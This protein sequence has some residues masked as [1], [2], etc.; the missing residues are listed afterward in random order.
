MLLPHVPFA[1][2]ILPEVA[3][4]AVVP[5][6]DD[7]RRGIRARQ[8]AVDGLE[9]LCINKGN[10]IGICLDDLRASILAAGS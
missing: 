3:H 6:K 4:G 2:L 8:D 1:D 10:L 9:D 7:N 5:L